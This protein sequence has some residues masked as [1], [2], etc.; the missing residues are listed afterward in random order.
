MVSAIT[1][2]SKLILSAEERENKVEEVEKVFLEGTFELDLEKQFAKW[3]RGG[4]QNMCKAGYER[5][6]RILRMNCT[7]T[8]QTLKTC[9][10]RLHPVQTKPDTNLQSPT[11]R[12]RFQASPDLAKLRLNK[13]KLTYPSRRL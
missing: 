3:R 13:A 9:R 7:L 2:L 12:K 8:V 1:E 10:A 4:I 6:S 5:T 11:R